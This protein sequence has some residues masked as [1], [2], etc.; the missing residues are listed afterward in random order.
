MYPRESVKTIWRDTRQGVYFVYCDALITRCRY[1][2]LS[3]APS[4]IIGIIPFLIW[5][6]IA[7]NLSGEWNISI[8]VLTWIMVVMSIGDYANAFNAI[9]QLPKRASVFNYGMHSYWVK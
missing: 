9:R 5:Y 3:L 4:V 8:M 2:V 1:V 7:P 6:I